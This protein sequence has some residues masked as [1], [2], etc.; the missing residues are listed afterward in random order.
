MWRLS[1][2]ESQPSAGHRPSACGFSTSRCPV[3]T[4]LLRACWWDGWMAPS[5]GCRSQCR[6]SICMLRAPNSPTAKGARVRSLNISHETY[7]QKFSLATHVYYRLLVWMCRIICVIIFN[8]AS[9]LFEPIV[10]TPW[11]CCSF[12]FFSVQMWESHWSFHLLS[13]WESHEVCLSEYWTICLWNCSPLICPSSPVCRL[14]HWGQT[15]CSR[16]PWWKDPLG[17]N[18]DI[19]EWAACSAVCLPGLFSKCTHFN[20]SM[21]KNLGKKNTILCTSY[22]C[23]STYGTFLIDYS[24]LT[25]LSVQDAVISLKWDPTGHLLLCLGRSEVV[26]ILGR[27]S[28]IWVT[29]HTLI[30]NSTVNVAEWCPLAGRAPD[31]RLMLAA[32]VYIT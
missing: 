18:W 21:L 19:W 15:F 13:F 1:C 9:I 20:S 22:P 27:S 29:L 31:P 17:L 25:A 10:M 8:V 14:A 7:Q 32:W 12:I 2:L 4:D 23:Q 11:S 5:A 3:R 30:H 28:G 6:K 24:T 26:K 16:L